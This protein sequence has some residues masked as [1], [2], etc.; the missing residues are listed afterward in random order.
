MKI[1]ICTI[2]TNSYYVLGARFVNRFMNFY[3]GDHDIHF[4]FFSDRDPKE[5]LPHLNNI[6]YINQNHSSW[7]QA[8]NSKF[9]NLLSIKSYDIDH[10]Y[11]FDADTNIRIDFK[12]WFVGDLVGGEHFGNND[13]MRDV[14]AYDRNPK[15]SCYIPI[16]TKLDQMYYLGAFWGGIKQSVLDVCEYIIQLQEKNKSIGYEPGV[17]DES[18]LNYYFHHNPPDKV[19]KIKDFPFVISD[20]GSIQNTRNVKTDITKLIDDISNSKKDLWDIQK[21][22]II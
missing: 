7:V 16:N 21:G 18:Y 17:N 15:S 6:T 12:D 8:V 13:W 4:F 19:V 1:G 2:A 11:F 10:L 14:K 22:K 5:V 9:T 3:K 20:K